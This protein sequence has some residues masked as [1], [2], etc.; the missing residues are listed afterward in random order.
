MTF[1]SITAAQSSDH[2]DF[3]RKRCACIR[4]VFLDAPQARADAAMPTHPVVVAPRL[5]PVPPAPAAATCRRDAQRDV[6]H[7]R[8]QCGR[9]AAGP[10]RRLYAPPISSPP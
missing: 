4:S 3:H 8:D 2:A 1:S 7:V 9:H 6:S 10:E 5:P